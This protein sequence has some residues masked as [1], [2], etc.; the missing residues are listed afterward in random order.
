MELK[1]L[2][3]ILKANEA[4]A[5]ENRQ[6]FAR[7]KILVLNVISSPGSGKTSILE[8]TIAHLLPE[9][10]LGVIEGDIQTSKDAERIHALGVPVV[11]INTQGGCHL[12][13][14]MIKM[15]LPDLPLKELECLIIENVGNLVCPADYQ[16]GEDMKIVVLSVTEGDDKPSK[17]PAIFHESQVLIINKMDLL[18]FTD[19]NLARAKEAALQ[20]NPHLLIFELSCK[21]G[22]GVDSWA[23]WLKSKIKRHRL[24]GNMG[25]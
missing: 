15:A 5:V 3:N 21:S 20:I 23:S 4:I 6:L 7:E 17:Y 25:Q 11:Q 18:P 10:R 19:F 16:L 22:Q 13:A 24:G 9:C 14:N 8:R 1:V 2:S 12:D